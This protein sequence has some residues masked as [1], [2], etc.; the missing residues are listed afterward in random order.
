[1]T[2]DPM[3]LYLGVPDYPIPAPDTEQLTEAIGRLCDLTT[4][5]LVVRDPAIDLLGF[6][7]VHRR[8]GCLQVTVELTDQEGWRGYRRWVIHPGG[9]RIDTCH[10]RPMDRHHEAHH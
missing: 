9:E 4:D 7:A 3:G 6:D 10:W 2:I 5:D 8:D 1:M